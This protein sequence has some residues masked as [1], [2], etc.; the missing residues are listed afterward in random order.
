LLLA[1]SVPATPVAVSPAEHKAIAP[2]VAVGPR[3][4]VY[5]AWLEKPAAPTES[6]GAHDRHASAMNLW[7][8]RSDDGGRSFTG[9]VRVNSAAGEVWGFATSKPR[10]AVGGSGTL[11]LLWPANAT[12]ASG[13]PILEIHY[14]RSTDRGASFEPARRLNTTVSADASALIHG[15]F[16]VAHAFQALAAG[17]DRELNAIWIDT[18]SLQQ[19]T[20]LGEVYTVRSTDDGASFEPETRLFGGTCPCCQLTAA[21]DAAARL[22]LGSRQV[23]GN[24]LRG[25]TIARS[26]D[27]GR[28]FAARVAVASPVWQLDGCPLKPTA[29]AVDGE[30]VYTAVFNGGAQPAGV[31]YSGSHDGGRSFGDAQPLHPESAVSDA[32]VLAVGVQGALRAVWHAKVGETRRLYTRS[33]ADHGRS[34][35]AVAE[36]PTPAGTSAYPALARGADSTYLVWQQGEQVW[37]D[38][39]P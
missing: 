8:A 5:V 19:A 37:L 35:G 21:Y 12:N 6:A 27:R 24:N 4:E 7:L 17:P 15:G 32:P 13:K 20:D 23:T 29:L 34:W 33:S 14:A 11:H 22:W 39:L 3:G 38:R 10:V 31:W 2:E 18:R 26:D 1:A 36:L 16:A 30:H 28:S 9:P 25:A